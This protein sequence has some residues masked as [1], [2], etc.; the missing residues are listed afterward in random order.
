MILV[1]ICQILMASI[2]HFA[3]NLS[4][5]DVLFFHAAKTYVICAWTLEHCD[6]LKITIHF[7]NGSFYCLWESCKKLPA[8]LPYT[9]NPVALLLKTLKLIARKLP[10]KTSLHFWHQGDLQALNLMVSG[11]KGLVGLFLVCWMVGWFDC[12]MVGWLVCRKT[13]AF[14]NLHLHSLSR[15]RSYLIYFPICII[16]YVKINI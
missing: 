13:L 5:S 3:P 2:H 9:T 11:L 1:C 15:F 4:T 16:P 12:V 10:W 14:Y 6:S 7:F 8:C